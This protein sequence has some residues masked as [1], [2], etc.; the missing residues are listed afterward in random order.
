MDTVNQP[1]FRK[2]LG[3]EDLPA[4][5]GPERLA[6]AY[7]WPTG[8]TV[9]ANMV[10]TLDGAISGV[11]GRSGSI[12][13]AADRIVFETLRATS[14]VIVVGAGTARAENY[15]PPGPDQLLVVIS[16]SG[17]LPE[18]LVAEPDR[19]RL[20][21]AGLAAELV[22]LRRTF[23]AE[24]VWA[25]D[26]VSVR[27]DQ[28]VEHLL[29]DGHQRILLEGGPKLLSEWMAA[30][31]VQQ[32]CLTRIPVLLGGGRGLLPEPVGQVSAAPTLLLESGG[33]LLGCWHLD[34]SEQ[35]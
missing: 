18:R 26:D 29:A 32:L 11:D 28:V 2:L 27:P 13:N 33:T 35:A 22:G 6:E 17:H 20:A 12:G 1:R 23:G 16:R 30:D 9:R 31:C 5:F 3:P 4:E 10:A 19:V 14:E 24:R 15:G 7:A 8:P 34:R 21:V 25:L